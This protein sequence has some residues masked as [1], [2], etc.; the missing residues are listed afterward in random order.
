[1]QAETWDSLGY[2]HHHLGQPLQAIVCYEH[3]I[4]LY[5]DFGDRYNEADTLAHLGDTIEPPVTSTRPARR[6]SRP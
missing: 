3:A 4:D 5:R 2:A 1:M 6:G